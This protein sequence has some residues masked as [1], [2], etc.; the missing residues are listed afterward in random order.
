VLENDQFSAPRKQRALLALVLEIHERLTGLLGRGVPVAELEA[1]DLSGALRARYDT[2][3]DG[4][5]EVEQIGR[6]LMQALD[7]LGG[8]AG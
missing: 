7:V 2:P 8:V 4:A 5:D 1:V 3:P 6:E